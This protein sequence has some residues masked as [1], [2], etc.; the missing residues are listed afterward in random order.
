MDGLQN[1]H[2]DF[3]E[4]L[5]KL[6]E[7]CAPNHN[8]LA[9]QWPVDEPDEQLWFF[10]HEESHCGNTPHINASS[11]PVDE[12]KVVPH[13]NHPRFQGRSG[14]DPLLLGSTARSEDA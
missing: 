2:E 8:N 5:R 1:S 13:G 12:N 7:S 9:C 11:R 6:A 4:R 10:H 3:E 14:D